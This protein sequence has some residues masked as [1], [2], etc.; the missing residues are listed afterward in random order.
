MRSSLGDT[1][2]NR[3]NRT[4]GLGA[5]TGLFGLVLC[6]IGVPTCRLWAETATQRDHLAA[7]FDVAAQ[8]AAWGRDVPPLARCGEPPAAPRDLIK[9]DFYVNKSASVADPRKKAATL[10]MLAPLW[11]FGKAVNAMADDVVRA[12]DPDPVRAACVLAWL[13]AWARGDA[14]GG[15]VS[16]WGRY[17]TLWAC[18]IAAGMG[19]LKVR[20]VPGLDGAARAR[21][22]AWLE[23][24]ARKAV[25]DNAAFNAGRDA[26]RQPRTNLSYWTAAGAAVAAVAAGRRD[27]YDWALATVRAGLATTRPDGALPGEMERQAR[28]F[29]YHIWGLEPLM[30][31]AAVAR[32]NG[33][34]LMAETDGALRRMVAFMLRARADP[35][36]FERLAGFPQ[37]ADSK[38]ERWPRKDSA[39]ALEVYLSLVGEDAAVEALM[40]PLRPV[41]TQF[42]G[43]DF[44]LLFA[45]PRGVASSPPVVPG[46]ARGP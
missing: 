5:A 6:L 37:Q 3:L 21:V 39:A 19:Y 31:V 9:P 42:S 22:E 7:P 36:A 35:A 45:R 15:V 2:L 4:Y 33:S 13:D 10:D 8:R 46:A 44:T 20:D 24:L 18:Q 17:D 14:L 34:D 41:A 25:A 43:G 32:A 26:R 11:A 1:R 23:Q 28:A 30:L 40:A 16:Q 38:P 29:V 12:R 27:L